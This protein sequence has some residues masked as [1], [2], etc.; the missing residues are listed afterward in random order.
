MRFSNELVFQT[1]FPLL[2][3]LLSRLPWAILSTLWALELRILSGFLLAQQPT[4]LTSLDTVGTAPRLIPLNMRLFQGSHIPDVAAAFENAP[5]GTSATAAT[6]LTIGQPL[7]LSMSLATRL[8]QV[9]M[10]E[11]HSLT[12]QISELSDRHTVLDVV[13]RVL[14]HAASGSSTPPSD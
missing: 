14:R 10:A 7:V 2:M 8:L 6:N 12:R 1:G 5:R 3:L 9:L 4:I 11:S 13:L